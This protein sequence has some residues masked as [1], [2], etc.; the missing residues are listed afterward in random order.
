MGSAMNAQPSPLLTAQWRHL[1]MLNY[2]ID[3]KL[4]APF[5]PA[6]TELDAWQGKT[7]VSLVGFLFQGARLFGRAVPCHGSFEEVNLRFYVRRK[8]EDGWRRAVVFVKEL[9]SRV[10]VAWTARTLYGENYV[11]APMSHQIETNGTQTWPRCV[12]YALR[13]AIP[14][15]RKLVESRDRRRRQ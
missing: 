11:V 3:R 7:Y 14:R 2:E 13:V 6:G 5:V 12:T 1:A 4:L 8:A 15:P 10:A 9:V